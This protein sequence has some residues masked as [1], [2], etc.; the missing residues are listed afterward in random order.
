[1]S[2]LSLLPTPK[3]IFSVAV[4]APPSHSKFA[5]LKIAN[6]HQ[7]SALHPRRQHKR[8]ADIRNHPI[9][10]QVLIGALDEYLLRSAQR[11]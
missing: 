2:L 8:M 1:M 3:N 6:F 5:I 4:F 11:G 10:R 9:T 7:I